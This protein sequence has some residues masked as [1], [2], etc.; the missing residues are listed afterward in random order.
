MHFDFS[1]RNVV[2]TGG[3][4]ALGTAVVQ[5]LIEEGAR[6]HVPCREPS[7]LDRFPYCGHSRVTLV[8][9]IDLCDEA[10]V[11][12]FYESVDDLWASVHLAGGFSM[13]PV[14]E[15][16]L[17]EFRRLMD[18]NAVT[19]FLCCREAAKRIRATGAG[20]RIVNVAARPALHAVSG[21][22]AYAASKA[23]VASITLNLAEELKGDRIWVNA[24]VPSI[25]DTP[26]NRKSQPQADYSRW[27][28]VSDVAST[29]VFLAS[30]RNVVTRGSLVTAYGQM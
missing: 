21:M 11:K 13:S 26:A 3:T 15:T 29:V 9:N 28:K 12:R 6:C 5:A 18:M 16:T 8:P 27:V 24:V 20:G 7:D 25:L 2:V 4:G 23:A 14:A 10:A 22:V 1:N 17:A 19:C 30:P